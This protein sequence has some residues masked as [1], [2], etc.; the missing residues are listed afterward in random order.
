MPRLGYRQERK[1]RPEDP[2]RREGD[3][4][5]EGGPKRPDVEQPN[6]QRLLKRMRQVDKDQAK[7][8]RQRTGQ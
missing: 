2:L 5:D 6:R 8:Y 4:T 7:R 1:Q 3:E